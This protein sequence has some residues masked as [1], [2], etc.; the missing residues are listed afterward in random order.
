MKNIIPITFVPGAKGHQIG[1]LISSCDNVIWFNHF[2]NG[3]RPWLP[4]MGME[5]GNISKFHFD[6]RFR[7]AVG[8]G[9]DEYTVPPVLDMAERNQYDLDET[10]AMNLWSKK[11][12]PFYFVYPLH[13]RL[14]A[15]KQLFKQAKHLVVLS[16][17]IENLVQRFIKTT[18]NFVYSYS[19][20]KKRTFYEYFKDLD[21]DT[22]YTDWVRQYVIS[23]LDNYKSNLDEN[24]FVI[25]DIQQLLD[26]SFFENL[27]DH[28]DLEFN[29]QNYSKVKEFVKED[30]FSPD[31]IT[32]RI[33]R[34]DMQ[35]LK[36]FCDACNRLGFNNNAS[37]S[38]MKFS[39][40]LEQNGSWWATIKDQKIISVSGI[41][42]F[43]DGWRAVF[44]GA[45]IQTRPITGLNKYQ[46][47]SYCIHSHLPLQIEYAE[48]ISGRSTPVYITTNTHNDASGR[49]SRINRSFDVMAKD[50]MVNH[51]ST[52]TIFEVEQNIWLLNKDRYFDLRR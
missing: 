2:K 32:K 43:M 14:D 38:A 41:H 5:M 24:D 40:C 50:G 33:E 19:D 47:Q 35:M 26:Q 15:S 8:Q 21:L 29:E 45:Q 42:P 13:S 20:P 7:G 44:R 10:Q 23:L 9:I 37:L 25:D 4:A 51:H 39:W 36:E 28:F 34:K 3:D 11:L 46:M 30:S 52:E 31:S 1:R 27:C 16:D 6:R 17:N 12:D 48:S 18:A 49:M 22:D